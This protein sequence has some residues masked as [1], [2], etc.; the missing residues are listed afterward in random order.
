MLVEEQKRVSDQRELRRARYVYVFMF[1][2][3][4]G[5]FFTFFLFFYFFND[6]LS[7]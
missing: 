4:F 1:N 7:L 2:L 6:A 3:L 5:F